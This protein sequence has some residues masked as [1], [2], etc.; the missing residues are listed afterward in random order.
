MVY[1]V[2]Y[3]YINM[4]LLDA[5]SAKQDE[6]VREMKKYIEPERA[7]VLSSFFKTGKGQYGEG[8]KFIGVTV[9]HTRL[10]AKKYIDINLGEVSKLLQ[11]PI[12]EIRLCAL[13]LLSLKVLRLDTKK[14]KVAIGSTGEKDI[15]KNH[16]GIVDVYLKL[17]Q[18]VNNWD[19]VDTSAY[20]IYGSYLFLYHKMDIFDILLKHAKS[21]NIWERRIAMVSTLYVI[22]TGTSLDIVTKV[23][24]ALLG[25]TEDLIH[26]AV[27]WMLREA[28]KKDKKVLIQFLDIHSTKMP[29]TA[30]RYAIEKLSEGERRKYIKRA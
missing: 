12:H 2:S 24:E 1:D 25:D 26:K 10:V 29:R 30:L 3:R 27:G 23:A 17:M 19:L 14:G 13:I 18:Y 28:G 20:H 6:V 21:K 22:R 9:P 15:Q 16:K 5:I 11:N 8:D 4:K 7:H